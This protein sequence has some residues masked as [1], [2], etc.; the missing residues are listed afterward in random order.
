MVTL[1]SPE[2]TLVF[3]SISNIRAPSAFVGPSARRWTGSVE[4][5]F[6][7]W[8]VET[9]QSTDDCIA[10]GMTTPAPSE[11]AVRLTKAV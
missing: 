2:P 11:V 4:L 9:F 10:T 1:R 6:V 7:K 8:P 5:Y 3:R